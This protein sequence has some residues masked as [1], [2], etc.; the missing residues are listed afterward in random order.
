MSVDVLSDGKRLS[1]GPGFR[2]R[3]KIV[4]RK[5]APRVG[6]SLEARQ[7]IALTESQQVVTACHSAG[8]SLSRASP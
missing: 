8:Q 1:A 2:L 7:L 5:G 4:A 6:H 3:V